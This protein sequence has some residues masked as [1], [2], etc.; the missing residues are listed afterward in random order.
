MKFDG[1]SA[2]LNEG[3]FIFCPNFV[4]LGIIQ[5][6]QRYRR[7]LDKSSFQPLVQN[8]IMFIVIRWVLEVEWKILL[9]LSLFNCL[10]F[11]EKSLWVIINASLFRNCSMDLSIVCGF[12]VKERLSHNFLDLRNNF[13]LWYMMLW[14]SI[15]PKGRALALIQWIVKVVL[16]LL[17]NSRTSRWKHELW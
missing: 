6:F 9:L 13:F 4:Y 5:G 16:C 3:F 8:M 12:Q 2:W 17:S 11:L 7:F 15:L 10:K 14:E 1:K